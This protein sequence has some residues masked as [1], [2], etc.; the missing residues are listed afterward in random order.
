MMNSDFDQSLAKYAEA[1]LRV[2]VNL[3][4]GQRLVIFGFGGGAPLNAAPLIRQITRSAYQMG[5][6]YVGILW[7]DDETNLLRF[8]HAPRDSFEETAPWLPLGVL[9]FIEKGDALLSVTAN[10]PDLLAGQDPRLV[11]VAQKAGVTQ[12][13]PVLESITRNVTPWCVVAASH[14]AWAAKVFAGAPADQQEALLWE[15]IM[16]ICRIDQPD[17]L[18]AWQEHVRRLTA[19]SEHLNARRYSDLHFVGPGT[20]LKVGLADG[21]LWCSAAMKSQNGITFTANMPTEEVFTLPH[22]ARVEG[23][24]TATKPLGYGGAVIEG[25]EVTFFQGRVVNIRAKNNQSLLDDLIAT[26]EGAARLGEVALTPHRSPI[27]QSGLLFYN[28]LIDENAASHV[29]LGRGYAFTVAGGATMN[30][31]EFAAVGGNQSL[32]H[33]DFMIGDATVDVDGI[34]ADGTKEPLMRDGEWVF[35]V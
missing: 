20:D 16:R 12:M 35:H 3:Q 31:D 14:P 28:T 11:A 25:I 5:A 6:R 4:P 24:V 27:S 19:V 13:R 32:V 18:A 9:D 26:D 34:A 21:H 1:I 8:Q 22:R 30:P 2:G 10:N 23:T 33:V 7:N 29:A 17:P 15:Q